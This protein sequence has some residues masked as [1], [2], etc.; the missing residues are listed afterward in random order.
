MATGDQLDPIR[1]GN[2]R[3]PYSNQVKLMCSQSLQQLADVRRRCFTA[4]EGGNE[5]LI[6]AD[7]AD[8]NHRLVQQLVCPAGQIQIRSLKLRFPEATR[9]AMEYINTGR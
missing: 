6:Q 1:V 8:R 9:A 3:A 2:Q 7:T 4:L 5:L